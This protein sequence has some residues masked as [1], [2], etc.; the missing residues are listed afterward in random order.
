MTPHARNRDTLAPNLPTASSAARRRRQG[1]AC[2][3]V[4]RLNAAAC[5]SLLD[6]RLKQRAGT[7]TGQTR[8]V[9]PDSSAVD[10]D[11][12]PPTVNQPK[13]TPTPKKRRRA[14]SSVGLEGDADQL[15]VAVVEGLSGQSAAV[16][17]ARLVGGVAGAE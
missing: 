16:G 11:P 7:A 17:T 13:S 8:P 15:P 6:S 14:A 1:I 5:A 12:Q 10:I 3:G 4:R 2:T 9:R